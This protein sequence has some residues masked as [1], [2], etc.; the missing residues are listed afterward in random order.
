MQTLAGTL[1]NVL[2]WYDFAIF[3][4]FSDIIAQLFFPP[5]DTSDG[6]N[7]N[8]VRSFAVYGGGFIM[9][10][11]GGAFIGYLGDKYGRKY[12]LVTSLFLMAVPTFAMGCLP[13]YSQIGYWSTAL[14]VL[15]RLAQGMSV[16][17]Q[18]P[19]SLIYTVVSKFAK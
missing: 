4:F 10:P 13:T 14:L 3:G 9:R 15:C 6:A 8:L 2:E 16:G 7:E 12:A 1:G 17:G 11:V 19:A 5:S 18:L